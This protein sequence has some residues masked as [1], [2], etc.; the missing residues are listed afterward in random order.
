MTNNSNSHGS[1]QNQKIGFIF[2]DEIHHI[3]HFITTAIELAKTNKVSIL[4]FPSKHTYL[5][6]S[7]KRLNGEDVILEEL[8][9]KAFRAFT[10]KLKNRDFPRKAFWMKKNKNYL[11][12]CFDALVFTDFIQHTLYK[13]RK[14]EKKPIFIYFAHGLAGRAY[15]FKKDLTYFDLH[16]VTGHFFYNQLKKRDLLSKQ[17]I[18]CGYPK[19]DAVKN[20]IRKN[21]FNNDNPIVLYNPHFMPPFSSW[22]EH[23][24]DILAFFYNN[25]DYNLIFA[26]HINLFADKGMEKKQAIPATYFE[27]K[28]IHLDLG[29]TQSVNMTYTQQA[30][31]YLGDVS[32]Q[33]YEFIINPRPCIFINSE[34]INY[35]K[36]SHYRFWQCGEVINTTEALEKALQNTELNFKKYKPIQE[37]IKEENI[38]SENGSTATQ[39]ASNAINTYLNAVKDS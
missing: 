24:L 26:P 36:D 37:K 12:S 4:T 3:D 34:K 19:I 28:N 9:T 32:S 1:V 29:S 22:H 17:N 7:L 21:Y 38:Y 5:R 20:Q 16:L 27:A 8:K 25:P 30:T 11:L 18:L 14:S 39:R 23:G 13:S 33:V 15:A 35:N 2:L 10:D 31:I 6:D